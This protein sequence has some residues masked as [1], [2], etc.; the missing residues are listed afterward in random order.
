ML[1]KKIMCISA[2]CA[3]KVVLRKTNFYMVY[4]KI[5]KINIK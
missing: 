2:L 4:V 3:Y 5:K 1:N